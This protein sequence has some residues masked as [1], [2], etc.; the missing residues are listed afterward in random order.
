MDAK[1]RQRFVVP[2][3]QGVSVKLSWSP[4]E[5]TLAVGTSDARL[6]LVDARAGQI[7]GTPWSVPGGPVS[8]LDFSADGGTLATATQ[9]GVVTLW[10]D[11]LWEDVD[12]MKQ[13]LCAVA[14]RSL[15]RREWRE[16]IPGKPYHATCR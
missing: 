6:L 2:L 7:L 10:D 12:A 15:S 9:G 14:G 11:V 3:P 5:S 1:G 16:F 4:D 13:R 8:G